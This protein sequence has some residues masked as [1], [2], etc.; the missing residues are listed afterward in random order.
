MT[1]KITKSGNIGTSASGECFSAPFL[2]LVCTGLNIP[3]FGR[4]INVR[5]SIYLIYVRQMSCGMSWEL[6]SSVCLRN[7]T[8]VSKRPHRKGSK[9]PGMYIPVPGQSIRQY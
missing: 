6:N 1:D 9:E 8:Q 4:L 2:E 3:I 5:V 7:M